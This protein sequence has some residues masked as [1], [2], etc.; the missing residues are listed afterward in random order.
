MTPQDVSVVALDGHVHSVTTKA[1]IS[2]GV[3]TGPIETVLMADPA[4]PENLVETQIRVN[5][6]IQQIAGT[7]YTC[8]CG[9]SIDMPNADLDGDPRFSQEVAVSCPSC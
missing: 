3:Q 4:D 6:V 9:L 7:R 5:P 8:G 2:I 1:V